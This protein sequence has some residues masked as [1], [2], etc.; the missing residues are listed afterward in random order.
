M[1]AKPG[2]KKKAEPGEIVQK[3][4]AEIT[5][6]K[7][8]HKI[9]AWHGTQALPVCKRDNGQYFTS[10]WAAVTCEHCHKER[11]LEAQRIVGLRA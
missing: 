4:L 3:A 5:E 9:R 6:G 8:V 2:R 7:T 10:F 1:K 11:E